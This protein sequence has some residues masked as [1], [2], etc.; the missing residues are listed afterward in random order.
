M[1]FQEPHDVLTEGENLLELGSIVVG[2]GIAYNWPRE[3]ILI[4]IPLVAPEKE[5]TLEDA[6]LNSKRKAIS[7]AQGQ[8]LRV[9]IL[10]HEKDRIAESSRKM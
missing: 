6:Q 1:S 3:A 2:E 8:L 10:T 9:Y 5:V 4:E 7:L